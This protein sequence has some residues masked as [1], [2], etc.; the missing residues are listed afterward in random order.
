MFPNYFILCG[1]NPPPS[2]LDLTSLLMDPFKITVYLIW[3]WVWLSN[4]RAYHNMGRASWC[5]GTRGPVCSQSSWTLVVKPHCVLSTPHFGNHR[6]ANIP[7]FCPLHSF[8]S[9][10][11]MSHLKFYTLGPALVTYWLSSVCS[12][13]VAQVCSHMWTYTTPLSAAMVW[14]KLTLNKEEDWQQMLA[15]GESSPVK[16]NKYNFTLS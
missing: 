1:P 6:N 5:H 13:S 4:V 12:A 10:S 7:Q 16:I 11:S 3:I 8:L 2:S 9:V 14:W 15:Q